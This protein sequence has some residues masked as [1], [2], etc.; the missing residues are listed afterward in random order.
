M[1]KTASVV[2]GTDSP[3]PVFSSCVLR[4]FQS[5]HFQDQ[6]TQ[7][8]SHTDPDTLDWTS[9]IKVTN[10][11]TAISIYLYAF[12]LLFRLCTSIRIRNN[13]QHCSYLNCYCDLCLPRTCNTVEH[14]LKLFHFTALEA[15][16]IFHS[17]WHFIKFLDF[18]QCCSFS[19]S[20]QKC[21]SSV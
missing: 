1:V 11:T 20:K 16:N 10:E 7:K 21:H 9:N 18:Q 8:S 19:D 4:Q 13:R 15:E 14:S 5:A 3:S 2:T 12:S 6:L 17:N